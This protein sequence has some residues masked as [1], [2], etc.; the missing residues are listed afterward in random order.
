MVEWKVAKMGL[1]LA[2]NLV[3]MS[4]AGKECLRV[5]KTAVLMANLKE[6]NSEKL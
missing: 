5:E 2:E 6:Q 3:V 4:V 1:K